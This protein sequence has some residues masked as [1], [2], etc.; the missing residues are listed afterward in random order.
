MD[1]HIP[2]GS[3]MLPPDT[4]PSPDQNQLLDTHEEDARLSAGATPHAPQSNDHDEEDA[5]LSADA[6]PHAPQS[7]DHTPRSDQAHG[8]RLEQPAH[9]MPTAIS[10]PEMVPS[11]ELTMPGE[12]DGALDTP[13]T[14]E[15]APAATGQR[16]SRNALFGTAAALALGMLAAGGGYYA[17]TMRAPSSAASDSMASNGTVIPPPVRPSQVLAANQAEQASPGAAVPTRPTP[18]PPRTEPRSSARRVP[19]PSVQGDAAEILSLRTGGQ[20]AAAPAPPPPAAPEATSAAA[21]PPSPPAEAAAAPPAPPAPV[22]PAVS[23][24]AAPASTPAAAPSSVAPTLPS[25]ASNPPDAADVAATF[26]PAFMTPQ[27]Q[28]DV[29]AL[30]TQMGALV[31]DMRDENAALRS[32]VAMLTETVQGRT[33]DFEQRLN[34]AE[35]RN[36]VAA[37]VGAGHRPVVTP[38]LS[39][40]GAGGGATRAIAAAPGAART[41]RDYRV[42]AASPGTAVLADVNAPPGQAAGLQVKAGEMVPGVGRVVSIAQRGTA[43]V[44]QTDHG[45]I[46]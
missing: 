35:A 8:D 1:S 17:W 42:Q 25:P 45:V 20:Q 14:P 27:A 16:S 15:A 39:T 12:D 5:R 36:S 3:D 41:V 33:T 34:L 30:V 28:V 11:A 38:I 37:A 40:P 9:A 26:R 44:V 32:Q 19:V 23:A 10:P 7:D 46:Q 6:A 22:R 13:A 29:L 21:L 31:R 24:E 18:V 43:W 4:H 2:S